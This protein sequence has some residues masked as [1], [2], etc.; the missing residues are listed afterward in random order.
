MS[1]T[2]HQ[3]RI[4]IW[5]MEV[6]KNVN[7]NGDLSPELYDI[8]QQNTCSNVSV[9]SADVSGFSEVKCKNTCDYLFI[10]DVLWSD[11]RSMCIKRTYKHFLNFRKVLVEYFQKDDHNKGPVF[12]PHLEG[13]K[14]FRRYT[15]DLAEEREAELHKFVKN[16]LNG[17]PL[18][19]STVPV[20]EFFEP[21]ASD[22]VPFRSN[23]YGHVD[24]S[25]E[26]PFSEEVFSRKWMKND[27]SSRSNT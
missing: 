8:M 14:L 21:K 25:D 18:V 26:D 23:R 7:L 9:T 15:R 22:P 16:L 13:L 24:D 1:G 12:I 10:V 27:N 3:Q 6:F 19:S 11:G 4:D 2:R 5:K 20:L 17:N